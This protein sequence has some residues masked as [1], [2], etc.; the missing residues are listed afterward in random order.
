MPRKCLLKIET[1]HLFI[2]YR[3]IFSLAQEFSPCSKKNIYFNKNI[4]VARKK[5]L[6][7]SIFEKKI[8]ASEIIS[9]EDLFRI[10][11]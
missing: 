6:I 7:L 1:K 8:L 5:I 9:V 10:I 3:K 4:L 11:S 2:S